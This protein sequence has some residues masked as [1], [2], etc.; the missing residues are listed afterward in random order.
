M[1]GDRRERSMARRLQ[2]E[3][4][5]SYL[6]HASGVAF[7]LFAA[8]SPATS[9]A[10]ST[11]LASR[12]AI[13][14]AGT[15]LVRTIIAAEQGCLERRFAGKIPSTAGCTDTGPS[16]AG[17]DEPATRDRI[18]KAIAKA[19]A[20]VTKKCADLSPT[21]PADAGL[22]M[23]ATCP[24]SEPACDMPVSDLTS[25]LD[26]LECAHVSTGQAVVDVP[27]GATSAI[28]FPGGGFGGRR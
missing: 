16:L 10:G 3:G 20:A 11:V 7:V 25:L 8:F 24:S 4:M 12:K 13:G 2:N 14:K 23:A 5:R 19:R 18:L 28:V 22:G 27:Y 1:V 15:S 9:V 26:C 21:A 17:V 6:R